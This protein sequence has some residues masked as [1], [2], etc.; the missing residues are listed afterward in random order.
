MQERQNTTISNTYYN[1]V[2]ILYHSLE[3]AQTYD[4]YVKD[5]KQTGDQDLA[6][7]FQSLHQNAN[8]QAQKAQ[9]LLARYSR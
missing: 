9:Q 2:S 8:Q 1:L 5:A 4:T 7:F 3:A 6:Q